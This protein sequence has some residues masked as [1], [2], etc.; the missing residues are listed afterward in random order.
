MPPFSLT[1]P[2]PRS[3]SLPNLGAGRSAAPTASPGERF[4]RPLAALPGTLTPRTTD[5]NRQ[6]YW[7]RAMAQLRTPRQTLEAWRDAAPADARGA[8]DLFV[9]EVER[10]LALGTRKLEIRDSEVYTLPPSHALSGFKDLHFNNCPRIFEPP[11]DF[12][13]AN[14]RALTLEVCPEFQGVSQLPISLRILKLDH[15][16]SLS[17]LPEDMSHLKA[18]S[19]CACPDVALS[20]LRIG[21]HL[22]NIFLTQMSQLTVVHGPAAGA[23]LSSLIIVDCPGLS[24]LPDLVHCRQLVLVATNCPLTSLPESI[25]Q[26]ARCEMDIDGS[27][28]S[29][30]IRNRLDAIMN[31]Q[32]WTGPHIET[33]LGLGD[34]VAPTRTVRPLPEE[35]ASWRPGPQAVSSGP[36]QDMAATEHG[37]QLARFLSRLRETTECTHPS[38]AAQFKSRVAHLIE[39]WEQ[40]PALLELCAVQADNA[41]RRCGDRVALAMMNMERAAQ[42]HA[43]ELQVQ[44]GQYDHDPEALIALGQGML[45]L[46]EIDKMAYAKQASMNFCDKTEVHLGYIVALAQ[47][48]GNPG[49]FALPVQM[50]TMLYPGWTALRSDDIVAARQTLQC[51][52]GLSPANGKLVAS[53]AQWGPMQSLLQRTRPDTDW[54]TKVDTALASRRTA[55]T[56]A[57]TELEDKVP[58]PEDYEAQTKNLMGQYNGAP[59]DVKHEL[60]SEQVRQLLQANQDGRTR[61]VV[62]TYFS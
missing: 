33:N 24:G 6:A 21:P 57:L 41:N 46:D 23:K 31:T 1:L 29:E 34:M 14:F 50:Q 55:I 19:V 26:W 25:A 48:P 32:S 38:T 27:S 2:I 58:R 12:A 43:V 10:Q 4:E 59:I 49:G 47:S 54:K 8:Y 60:L 51:C 11:E 7:Q 52:T 44:A 16:D 62:A 42:I 18:L 37:K 30:A 28:L 22:K 15:C 20:S 5:R 56:A 53:L 13:S 3:V 40:H 35:V 61:E 17:D 39:Q 9:N 45:Y 36:W